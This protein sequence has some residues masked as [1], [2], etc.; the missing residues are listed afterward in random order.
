M[1]DKADL[2]HFDPG[3]QTSPSRLEIARMSRGQV[4]H[5]ENFSIWNEHGRVDFLTPVNLKGVV[6]ETPRL[7]IAPQVVEFGED[8]EEH[9]QGKLLA[10]PGPEKGK[11]GLR[12]SIWNFR[13][14]ES[15]QHLT[16][17]QFSTAVIKSLKKRYPR[18]QIEKLGLRDRQ[19]I[20]RI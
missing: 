2:P 19:L 11:L 13:K 4:E 10:T 12:L 6:L 1:V 14:P 8:F 7:V 5:V 16:E 17:S 9:V 20:F 3:F 18:V 15:A